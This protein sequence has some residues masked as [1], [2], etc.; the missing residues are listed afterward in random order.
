MTFRIASA[1]QADATPTGPRGDH[2][3]PYCARRLS[4]LELWAHRGWKI[5]SFGLSAAGDVLRRERAA[6]ADMVQHHL[7]GA[8]RGD[9][10]LRSRGPRGIGFCV[11]EWP[12]CSFEREAW[13]RHVIS[14]GPAAD[15]EANLQDRLEGRV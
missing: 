15:V 5:R 13:S 7:Y 1:S 8:P 14:K 4:F 9:V 2:F 3:Q 12:V 6:G 11:W 10:K